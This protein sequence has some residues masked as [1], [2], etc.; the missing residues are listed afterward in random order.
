MAI[1]QSEKAFSYGH[2]NTHTHTHTLLCNRLTT[3]ELKILNHRLFS[4]SYESERHMEED[5]E[6]EGAA[7]FRAHSAGTMSLWCLTMCW[8]F[9]EGLR[10]PLEQ[11]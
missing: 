9:S 1:K 5:E 6:E 3:R 8:F 2:D 11:Y 10:K 7:G 4:V